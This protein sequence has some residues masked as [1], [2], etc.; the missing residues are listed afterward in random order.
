MDGDVDIFL[1]AGANL[2][3]QGGVE[4]ITR[5]AY[6]IKGV[7]DRYIYKLSERESTNTIYSWA[8]TKEIQDYFKGVE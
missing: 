5:N 4:Y 8:R 7:T 2:K 3:S 6:S 1:G